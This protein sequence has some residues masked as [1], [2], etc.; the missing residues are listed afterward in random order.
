MVIN[1]Y[2]YTGIYSLPCI[3]AFSCKYLLIV[4]I[5][6]FLLLLHS[7]AIRRFFGPSPVRRCITQSGGRSFIILPRISLYCVKLKMSTLP[8]KYSCAQS[9]FFKACNSCS[10]TPE[11]LQCERYFAVSSIMDSF[12]P[13]SPII[14][15]T[16]GRMRLRLRTASSNT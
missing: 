13:G 11:I 3:I 1:S 7:G 9:V 6:F 8:L 4:F 12:S 14:I 15:W 5:T 2:I 16:I 10:F